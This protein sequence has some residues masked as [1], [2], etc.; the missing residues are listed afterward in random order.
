MTKTIITGGSG[1]FGKVLK[2]KI[3]SN[4]IFPTKK[5]LNITSLKSINTYFKKVK[6]KI[7]I[8]LAGLSRPLDQHE[9]QISKSILLNI[10]GTCNLVM[11]C[12]KFNIKIIYFSSSYVYPGIKGNYKETDAILP[13]NNYSWS[14]LGG[15][16]AVQMY[17]N[18][19]IM[20]VC[21]T[22]RPFVHKK[23]FGDVQLNF[24]FHDEV[25]NILPQLI[26]LKGIINVGGKTQSIYKFAKKFNPRVK[27]IS[28]KKIKNVN[29]P[30]KMTMNLLKLNKLLKKN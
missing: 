8:H 18:S 28:V 25:A 19:L 17:K 14:K 6:P 10:V 27:K 7:I 2:L 15:E 23:A 13:S 24:M 29:F 1:R 30:K 20:R 3:Y 12:Q 22:E 11:M 4:F 5:Q 21:M 26:K 9:S 16:A